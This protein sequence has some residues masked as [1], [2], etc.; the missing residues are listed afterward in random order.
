MTDKC[1]VTIYDQL[2]G[3]VYN[4][5]QPYYGELLF[6]SENAASYKFYHNQNCCELVVIKEIVGDLSD[7][8]GSPILQAESVT[9]TDG[10]EAASL[11]GFESGTWTFYKFSTIKGS[12]TVTWLGLSSGYYSETVDFC[13]IKDSEV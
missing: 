3:N 10:I 5:I 7:I 9:K 8:C 11:D 2:I 12:V 4:V 1:E 6:I 13:E